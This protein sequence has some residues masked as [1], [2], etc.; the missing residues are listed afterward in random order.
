M[1]KA[2]QLHRYV[3]L[4]AD[5]AQDVPASH[6]LA[7]LARLPEAYGNAFGPNVE[8]E[9]RNLLVNV[10]WDRAARELLLPAALYEF[11]MRMANAFLREFRNQRDA[12][13][14]DPAQLG[15]LPELLEDRKDALRDLMVVFIK[16]PQ[17]GFT[18]GTEFMREHCGGV[19]RFTKIDPALYPAIWEKVKAR[20]HELTYGPPSEPSVVTGDVREGEQEEHARGIYLRTCAEAQSKYNAIA[21]LADTVYRAEYPAGAPTFGDFRSSAA[22]SEH[23]NVVAPARREY[24]KTCEAAKEAYEQAR[25][26][27]ATDVA[28]AP[29]PAHAGETP[30][31]T[32]V[33]QPTRACVECHT[34]YPSTEEFFYKD[35]PYGL[36]R[37]CRVCICARNADYRA[38]NPEAVAK[39]LKA[40]RSKNKEVL[41]AKNR[42]RYAE[43][44]NTPEV[45]RVDKSVEKPSAM[46]SLFDLLEENA[47]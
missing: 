21:R 25:P 41:N 32:E 44:R 4:A 45:P 39:K 31:L 35:N 1:D 34:V 23:Q 38:K 18:R 13:K 37:A 30:P 19:D 2:D 36:R 22:L 27:K 20:L 46:Q 10:D 26:Q 17:V 14:Y 33:K 28:D 47:N 7:D 9:R 5:G 40:Y 3:A 15:A 24:D 43:K 16:H 8:P 29:A 6:L 42:A 12:G 11:R